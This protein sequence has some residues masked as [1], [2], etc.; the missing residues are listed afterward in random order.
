VT[1]LVSSGT[2]FFDDFYDCGDTFGQEE[3]TN[4][5]FYLAA[6][7]WMSAGIA[8]D[9]DATITIIIDMRTH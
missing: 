4:A 9:T 8:F 7:G 6:A 3:P 5:V 2:T 1:L